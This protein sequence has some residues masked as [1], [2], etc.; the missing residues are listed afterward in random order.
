MELHAVNGIRAVP[1]A[2]DHAFLGVRGELE[3][4]RQRL[5]DHQR[6]IASRRR[7]AA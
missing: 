2:H 3:I 4:V 6:V 1:N 7:R 5:S